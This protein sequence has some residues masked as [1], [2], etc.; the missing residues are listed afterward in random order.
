MLLKSAVVGIFVYTTIKGLMPLVGTLVPIPVVISMIAD[1]ALGLIRNIARRRP[2]DGRRRLRH[3]AAQGRQAD[4]DDQGRGQAG[5]Q[6]VRGRPAG[7]ERDPRPPARGRPQPDDGRRPRGRRRPGQPDPRRR[8]AAL[9]RRARRARGWWPAVPARSPPDPREGGGEQRP[10]GSRR[11]AR[12][13]PRT[14]PPRSAT[15]S[16]RSSS[17]RSPRCSRS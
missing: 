5:A 10:D 17:P 8:R 3:A 2:G 6:A 7:Q 1:N 13:R 4:A 15:R 12:P 9:R 16:R 11:P 14:P